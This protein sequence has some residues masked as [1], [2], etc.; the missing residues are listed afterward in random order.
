MFLEIPWF[1]NNNRFNN[2]K[3]ETAIKIM[4]MYYYVQ[5]RGKNTMQ[6][7]QR[8]DSDV[9]V[10]TTDR[11]L[12]PDILQGTNRNVGSCSFEADYCA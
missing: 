2:A 4:I 11:S 1:N 6:S 3:N 5:P 9:N 8:T 7:T 10:T 12:M